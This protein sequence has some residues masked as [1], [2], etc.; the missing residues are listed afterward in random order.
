MVQ[1]PAP[2]GRRGGKAARPVGSTPGA[3]A[4]ESM[5]GSGA[6][7][8]TGGSGRNTAVIAISYTANDLGSPLGAAPAD[9]WDQDAALDALITA[10]ESGRQE[11]PPEDPDEAK[12]DEDPGFWTDPDP[13]FRA[14]A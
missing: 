12:Y 4:D 3:G 7:G 8:G 13:R 1:E 14:T 6:G 9:D 5:T 2:D 11:V 10:I